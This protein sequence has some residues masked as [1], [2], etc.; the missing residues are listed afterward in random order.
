M[1]TVDIIGKPQTLT[2]IIRKLQT[3]TKWITYTIAFSGWVVDLA[4]NIKRFGKVEDLKLHDSGN[5][6]W[7]VYSNGRQLTNVF[8]K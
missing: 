5:G 7:A 2:Q 1:R 3:I 6:K 4:G 8:F